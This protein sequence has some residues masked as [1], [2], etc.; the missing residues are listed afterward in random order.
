MAE[1]AC[2][3][4]PPWL[5]T[6]CT[7][8]QPHATPRNP[9]CHPMQL[10]APCMQD[11]KSIS[12]LLGEPITAPVYDIQ[13]AQGLMNTGGRQALKDILIEHGFSH[14]CKNNSER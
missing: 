3:S 14:P 11:V 12:Q 8:M 2:P 5:G 4:H 10:N 6:L 9:M 13:L 7:P 1:V